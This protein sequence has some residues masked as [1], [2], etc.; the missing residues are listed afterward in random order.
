VQRAANAMLTSYDESII[1]RPGPQIDRAKPYINQR[2]RSLVGLTVASAVQS[3]FSAADGRFVRYR[4]ADLEWDL[5]HGYLIAALAISADGVTGAEYECDAKCAQEAHLACLALPDEGLDPVAKALSAPERQARCDALVA[6]VAMKDLPWAPYLK[7]PE[8][9]HVIAAW[10]KEIAALVDLGAIVPLEPGSP[11]WEEAVMSRTTTPC[12]VL[13]DFKRDCT[14]KCRCV[15]RGDLEDKVALDGPDFHYHTNV[16][17]MSSVRS[18]VLRAGRH[19]RRPGRAGGRVISTCDVANAYLQSDPFPES[20]RRFLKIRSPIDGTIT[21]YRQLIC[22]YGSCSAGPRWETTFTN[23]LTT[24]ESLGGPGF[25][26]GMNEPSC[27]HHPGRDLLMILYVDGQ[28]VDGY[29][30]DVEWYYS[31]LRTR[32]KVKEPQ[33]L[34]TTSPIDHL[35]VGIFQTATHIYMSMENYIK[36]MNAVL[37]RTPDKCL[38]RKSPMPHNHEITDMT[39]LS[40]SKAAFFSRALG[41]CSWIHQCHCSSRRQ[42]RSESH[43]PVCC[44]TMPGCL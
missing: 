42:I 32:F 37:Q 35:G 20:D 21:Y 43:Q 34:T 19:M 12:R 41:M 38:H 4:R 6:I 26:R 23:W 31:L 30:E 25:V 22:V 9:T 39:P 8:R 13:L 15:T 1:L 44:D 27:F 17:R 14:W 28:M 7:G 10:H 16:S 18:A 5:D 36:S 3:M 2:C 33:W 40:H 24:P 29:R 11:D